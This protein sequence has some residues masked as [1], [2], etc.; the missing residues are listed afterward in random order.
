MASTSVTTDSRSN[1]PVFGFAFANPPPGSVLRSGTS[2]PGRENPTVPPRATA[3]RQ[4]ILAGTDPVTG[5]EGIL[6][7][8]LRQEA[9]KTFRKDPTG[10]TRPADASERWTC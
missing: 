10:A 6:P 3:H 7:E 1:D 5:W 8:G 2:S 9:R 4:E